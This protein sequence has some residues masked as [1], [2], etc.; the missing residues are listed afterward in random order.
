MFNTHLAALSGALLLIA[1]AA[2]AFAAANFGSNFN[3][4]VNT[5]K[6]T[7]TGDWLGADCKKM[8]KNCDGSG[9]GCHLAPNGTP[10]GCDCTL[11]FSAAPMSGGFQHH[12]TTVNGG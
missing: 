7:C 2:P 3:C 6:C 10:I 11:G 12:P 4:D 5:R 1:A 9:H 8:A